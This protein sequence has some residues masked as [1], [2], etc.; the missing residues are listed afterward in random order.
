MKPVFLKPGPLKSGSLQPVSIRS[1]L[2]LWIL[3][4]ALVAVFFSAGRWQL[5][6]AVE[7]ETLLAESARVLSEREP[8]PLS[9]LSQDAA[10]GLAWAAGRGYFLPGPALLLDNQRRG[11]AVGVT[12]YRVFL[13]EGGRPLLVDLGWLPLP[14]DRVLPQIPAIDGKQVLQGLLLPPPSAGFALG[15]D[16]VE[17]SPDR[18]LLTR[19][20]IPALSS[21]LKQPLSTRVF[22]PDPTIRIGYARSLHALPNTLP[23]ERHRGYALQWFGLALATLAFALFLQFR[24]R[25]HDATA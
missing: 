23:P 20:D 19:V 21:A 15:P 16:H 11:E 25:R 4:L 5:H 13:P 17:S 7:K 6:R 1:R 9:Q 14:L 18:W 8:Q 10:S 12:V 22:R 24:A 3:A 2:L